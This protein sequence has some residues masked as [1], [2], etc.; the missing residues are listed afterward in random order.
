MRI[1]LSWLRD[2]VDVPWPG[3]ELGHRLTMAGFELEAL[4]TAAP[5]FSGVVVAEI[6]EAA[7]HPQA[8]KL[9]VCKVRAA[10]GELLQIVCGAANARAGLKTALATVG[11][12]LPGDKAIGAATLRG[13]DSAGMLCS[14]KELGLSDASEGILELPAD[15]PVGSD[16]R[17]YLQLDDEVLE[18]NVTPNRGDAMSVLGIARE[19][20]A[21]TRS[22]VRLPVPTDTAVIQEKHAVTLSAPAGCPKFTCRIVRGIDNRKASPPWLRERLRRAGLRSISPVVDITQYVM[23][24]LGQPMH[25]YDLSKL[26]GGLEA[27]YALPGEPIKLLDGTE[28]TLEPDIVVIA[29][30][31]G[32]VGM[33]GVMG[34]LASSCTAETTDILF[35]AAFFPPAAIAGR[36]RRHKLV[37]D[38]GQRFER[39]VD[40]IHQERAVARATGLLLDIAGGRAG[41]I[42]V[43][44]LEDK[45]P[46]RPEVKLRRD[47]IA[48]LL[49]TKIA[50][51][52]VKQTLE[53]LGMRVVGGGDGWLV[54]PPPHRFDISIEADL[55]EE[56][57]RIVGFE[58]IAETPAIIAQNVR[59]L[60]EEA[61]VET[62]ALE[63]LAARGYQEA[64]TYAFVDPA[65]QAKLFP[66][67]KT[68]VLTNAIS[69]EMSVMRTSLWPGLIQAASENMRRQQDRVRL[70]EH[71]AKFGIDV[72]TDLLAGIAVGSRRPE[73]WGAKTVLVDFFDV[74]AD[75]EALFARTGAAEEFG[76]VAASLSCL[77]P[78]RSARITRRGTTVGWIGEL[79]PEL[80]REF[81]FTYGPIL[82]EIEY[83]AGLVAKMPRFE[84]ISRFP[85]VRRD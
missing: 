79:H 4:E 51:N 8:E 44:Q 31:A 12:K 83:I 58:A 49:G 22:G 45:L 46:R 17:A 24:E 6:V 40:P 27:R 42:H 10:G 23:L 47:R 81:D 43:V 1:S 33:G 82:F 3:K 55:I 18:L 32:A 69:A 85:R 15:A 2:F 67:A 13:V 19:V 25:A 57:A 78:G 34:G 59:A 66:G 37:T 56:L 63:I 48:S 50:D 29:D 75:L 65:L 7:K 36:G 76:F 41:P 72:E 16:F 28:I 70:F 74:K 77:H 11:A 14:A 53:S 73:Q 52:D 9:Q 26:K 35:E 60:A 84:E 54:T 38:A 62:Q 80:V 68:P 20:A 61:P 5:P 21:L 64:I 30:D 71:G 39:G